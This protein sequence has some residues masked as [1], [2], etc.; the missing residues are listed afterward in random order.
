MKRSLLLFLLAFV[1]VFCAAGFIAC[2]TGN[3]GDNGQ[4]VTFDYDSEML[5][6]KDNVSTGYNS[7][8]FYV[9]TL[10]FEI[11]DPTVI[12]ITEGEEAGYFYAYGTSDE[13]GCHGFQAWRS[14]DLSHWECTGIALKP[15]FSTTW[16]VQNY[17]APEII[18]D[19]EDKLYYLF[20]NAFNIK[21][22]NRLYLSVAYSDHPVGP[23]VSP[24]GRKDANGNMLYA[25]KPVFD[26]TIN[27]PVIK[28][29]NE[30]DPDLIKENALDISPFIDPQTGE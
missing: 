5:S 18:Y 9:N 28:E 12:Y 22:S 7:N 1:T 19:E 13:I 11:A 17:W 3:G 16:A 10:E 15:D 14:K 27:N 20:Y 8:L 30:T 2:Q 26:L 29:M 24:D 23:F 6:Q 4:A 25:S 21:D